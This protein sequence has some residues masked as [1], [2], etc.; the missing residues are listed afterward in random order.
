MSSGVEGR[1]GNPA[2][3]QE[4]ERERERGI[5]RECEG[6]RGR[7]KEKGRGKLSA[8]GLYATSSSRSVIKHSLFLL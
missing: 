7:G 8:G 3:K 4:S 5:K 6:E 1:L 2:E